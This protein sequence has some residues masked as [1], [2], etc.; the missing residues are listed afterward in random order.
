MIAGH[1]GLA[2]IVK[3]REPQVPLWSLMLATQFM[4]VVFVPLLI[5][6]VE[7]IEP[8]AGSGG[9][10][11]ESVIHADYTHSLLGALVLGALFGWVSSFKWG[12]RAGV[13]LG[14]VVFSHWVLDLLF[15]RGDMPV[16][17]GNAGGLP[18]LGLGLWQVPAAAL[19]V[20]AGLVAAGAYLYWRAAVS[21]T[22]AAGERPGRA[23]LAGGVAAAAGAATLALNALGY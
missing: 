23:H 20:E 8:V 12:R 21:A 1:F 4:D 3:A 10:Y 6:G 15:H 17:P 16:L 11:G 5:A 19:L 14:A 7:T 22:A 13:V 2:A 18:L 9:G